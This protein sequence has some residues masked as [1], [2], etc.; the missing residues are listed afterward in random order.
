MKPK[1]Q[2][3]EK[4]IPLPSHII[5]ME[6]IAEKSGQGSLHLGYDTEYK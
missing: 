5:Q 4:L 6:N 1:Q 2:K 3:L